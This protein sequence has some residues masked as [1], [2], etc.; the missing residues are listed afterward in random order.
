MCATG[1]IEV[2]ESVLIRR[3][4]FFPISYT[5]DSM[6]HPEQEDGSRHLRWICKT[7]LLFIRYQP[8]CLLVTYLNSK[9]CFLFKSDIFHFFAEICCR[10]W[11]VLACVNPLWGI[12]P[13]VPICDLVTHDSLFCCWDVLD[14]S[15]G[16]QCSCDIC[17]NVLLYKRWDTSHY[18]HTKYHSM[19]VIVSHT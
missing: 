8:A 16:L 11:E 1:L 13:C 12:T 4:M 9:L 14:N 2:K 15:G 6:N 5:N 10:Y 3:G 17:Y 19:T 18:R 7:K